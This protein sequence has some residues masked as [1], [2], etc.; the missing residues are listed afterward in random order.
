MN[1]RKRTEEPRACIESESTVCSR[2]PQKRNRKCNQQP[3]QSP[4]PLP[5]F[6]FPGPQTDIQYYYKVLELIPIAQ[7]ENNNQLSHYL[8]ELLRHMV[9]DR[10]AQQKHAV[11]PR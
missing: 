9:L 3:P 10:V 5:D 11:S 4:L 2:P 6:R 1:I 8:L 7:Q